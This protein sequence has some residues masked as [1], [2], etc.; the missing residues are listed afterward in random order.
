MHEDEKTRLSTMTEEDEMEPVT[1]KVGLTPS[2]LA[3]PV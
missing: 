1:I 3:V 2:S